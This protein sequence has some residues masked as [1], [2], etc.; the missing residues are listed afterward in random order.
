MRVTLLATG[1]PQAHPLRFGPASLVRARDRA[2]L[3]DCGSGVT[4]RLIAAGCPGRNLDG[5]LLTHLLRITWSRAW[6]LLVSPIPPR[7]S[8]IH[9]S[10]R[11]RRQGAFRKQKGSLPSLVSRRHFCYRPR[12]WLSTPRLAPP[13]PSSRPRD[14]G[15]VF[16]MSAALPGGRAGSASTSASW[17]GYGTS[18]Q[19]PS[20]T[21][22]QPARAVAPWLHPEAT[23][24]AM[25]R[26]GMPRS[27]FA[28]HEANDER[29]EAQDA[30]RAACRAMGML[31]M[32]GRLAVE[33][34]CYERRITTAEGLD[35]LREALSRLADH[36]RQA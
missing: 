7:L 33:V 6:L 5:L 4:Q 12:P 29:D 35:A 8:A 10:W 36:L 24:S 19:A 9:A 32:S 25:D 26:L 14:E 21:P 15:S 3:V 11:C 22:G 17:N 20:S 30:L 2:F 18:C 1:C 23:A 31:G 16:A 28:E 27:G 13:R 34:V